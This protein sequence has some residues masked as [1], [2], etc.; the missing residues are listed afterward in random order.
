MIVTKLFRPE[1]KHD[2]EAQQIIRDWIADLR[3]DEF[4]Q[5]HGALRRT[6]ASGKSHYCCLGVLCQRVNPNAWH[7]TRTDEMTV[8][9]WTDVVYGSSGGLLPGP[10]ARRLYMDAAGKHFSNGEAV[11]SL[12]DANDSGEYSFAKIADIIEA[13]LTDALK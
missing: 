10:L 13:G 4:Q 12:T 7:I 9:V 6:T 11:F 5:A 1:I 8:E 3:S 2:L